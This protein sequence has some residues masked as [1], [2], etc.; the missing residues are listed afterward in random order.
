MHVPNSQT[1]TSPSSALATM[2]TPPEGIPPSADG[3]A[4]S[5]IAVNPRRLHHAMA[6]AMSRGS[7]RTSARRKTLASDTAILRLHVFQQE[8]LNTSTTGCQPLPS[9][10]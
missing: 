4:G 7:K 6:E 1:G 5:M 8:P 10:V 2:A 9:S 3:A